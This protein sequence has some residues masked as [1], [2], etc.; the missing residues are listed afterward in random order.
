M[1]QVCFPALLVIFSVLSQLS[2]KGYLF[3]PTYFIGL[4]ILSTR[5]GGDFWSHCGRII[6][7]V[8]VPFWRNKPFSMD[9]WFLCSC[10]GSFGAGPAFILRIR[11]LFCFYIQG[12]SGQ[13]CLV[14]IKFF[15]RMP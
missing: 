10:N 11:N 8:A 9:R 13:G 4:I 12:V 14:R 6:P 1:L 5:Q 7:V 3:L 2:L 15:S